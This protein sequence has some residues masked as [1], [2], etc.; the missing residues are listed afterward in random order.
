MLFRSGRG[1]GGGVKVAKSIDDV[2]RLATEI[3]GMQLVTHQT[4]PG[5]QKVRR[6]YI[7]EG[8]DIQKAID[9]GASHALESWDWDFYTE[10]VRVEK[11][12]L[13]TSQMKPYFELNRVLNDGVFYA[14][15]RLNHALS[16]RGLYIHKR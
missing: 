6:L 14:S 9:T 16:H 8:A 12:Q 3:L 10:K 7:E 13:D 5:G 11:Y 4:G 15:L 2:K 1:K